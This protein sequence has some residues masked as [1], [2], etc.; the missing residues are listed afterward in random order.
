VVGYSP[1][2]VGLAFLPNTLLVGVISLAAVPYLLGRMGPKP[3]ILTGLVSIIV[4][5]L[6]MSRAPIHSN[7][8]VDILPTF[9]LVGVDSP[10]S[11]RRRSASHFPTCPRLTPG[12]V[13]GFTNVSVQLGASIGTALLA[14]VSAGR[15]AQLLARHV[16]RSEALAR[17][18]HFGFQVAAICSTV[19]FLVAALLLRVRRA[20]SGVVAADVPVLE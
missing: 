15:T 8:A 4:G 11:S 19:A 16:A 6:W 17:G 5:L 12:L 14:S 9:L 2:G 20:G 18:F 1:L 13:S 10:W 3:L 7:Y